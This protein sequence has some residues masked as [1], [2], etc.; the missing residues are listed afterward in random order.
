MDVNALI[1]CSGVFSPFSKYNYVLQYFASRII[2]LKIDVAQPSKPYLVRFFSAVAKY[3][4]ISMNATYQ[5]AQVYCNEQNLILPMPKTQAENDELHAATSD[6]DFFLGLQDVIKKGDYLWFDRAA[7]TWTNF[8]PGKIFFSRFAAGLQS[9]ILK[10][11]LDIYF[12]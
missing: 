5:E 4:S 2:P 3:T 9:K 8:L 12:F 1:Q 10:S 6:L 11:S 7:M